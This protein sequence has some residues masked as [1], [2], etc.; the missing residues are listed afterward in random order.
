MTGIDEQEKRT[1]R[2]DGF[3]RSIRSDAGRSSYQMVSLSPLRYAGGKSRAIGHLLEHI[4]R[5]V[6]EVVSP[7][8][9][10]GSFEF[11]L[12]KKFG[13]HITGYDVFGLLVNYW[14]QQLTNRDTLHEELERLKPDISTFKM[15]RHVLLHY[16]EKVKPEDL[17]YKTREQYPL[18]ENEKVMLDDDVVKRAAYY[19]FN[20][21]L[22]YGPMFIGWPSS[23]YLEEKRYTSILEKVKTF[24]G[25]DVSVESMPFEKS[26]PAHDGEFLF[27]DPPYCLSGNSKMFCGIYPNRNF[28]VHHDGFPHERLS[29]LLRNHSGG[30]ML[31]YN[32]CNVIRDLYPGY[33]RHFPKWQYSLGQGE[34]RIGKNRDGRKNG[35]VKRSHEIILIDR[36]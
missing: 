1:R 17:S 8:F 4:P 21:Q 18:T 25:G 7:F 2:I 16:W 11:V 20:H 14:K 32:D 13:I 5:S 29:E 10:G 31:T 28:P 35:N 9:G 36:P 26:I 15:V 22:S 30:F 24:E 12:S 27:C 23:I 3:I 33:E 34:S 6:D 19:Y